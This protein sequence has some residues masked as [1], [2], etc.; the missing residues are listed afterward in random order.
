[1]AYG[2]KYPDN[3]GHPLEQAAALREAWLLTEGRFIYMFRIMGDRFLGNTC[4]RRKSQI[5]K[6][7]KLK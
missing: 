2:R 1:M 4:Q 7:R 5:Q 6:E 3:R